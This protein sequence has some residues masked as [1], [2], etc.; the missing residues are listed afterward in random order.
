MSQQAHLFSD[1]REALG[2]LWEALPEQDRG[3][4][5]SVYAGLIARAARTTTATS[6]CPQ[7][8]GGRWSPPSSSHPGRQTN[9]VTGPAVAQT[10]SRAD[11]EEG[12]VGPT[13]GGEETGVTYPITCNP[14]NGR[15]S[16]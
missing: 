13:T 5:I 16:V 14:D 1:E 9:D 7:T 12:S 3:R 11:N 8:M 2:L 4:V 6:R 15:A 10:A